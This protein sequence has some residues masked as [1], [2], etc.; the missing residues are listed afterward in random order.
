MREYRAVCVLWAVLTIIWATFNVVV[1]I[2][3]QWIGDTPESPGF[4]HHGV[5][6]YC[7]PNNLELRYDCSGAFTDFT[8][9]LNDSY[10]AT[11]FFVGVSALLMLISVAALLLF[12]CF[13]KTAVFILV[14]LFELLTGECFLVVILKTSVL[15]TILVSLFVLLYRSR[16]VYSAGVIYTFLA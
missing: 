6:K 12:F 8:T 14:G 2:Q 16:H 7:Y 13:K 4:G 1:F 5:Y 15:F 11:T 10:K 9:L 3:P